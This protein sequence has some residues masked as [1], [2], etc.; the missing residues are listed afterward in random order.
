MTGKQ[1]G[2]VTSLT[3]DGKSILSLNFLK[4]AL[5]FWYWFAGSAAACIVAALLLLRY[6]TPRYDIEASLLVRDDA[7]GA[8]FEDA[9][10]FEN[11]GH[12]A[13]NS[14]VDNEVE[15][16][17]SRN[18]M[19][20]VVDTLQLQ[21]RCIAAGRV[22]TSELYE[23]SPF[24]INF[25]QPAYLRKKAIYGLRFIGNDKFQI[26]DVTKSITATFGDTLLIGEVPAIVSRTNHIYTSDDQYSIEIAEKDEVVARYGAALK[27]SV[28]NKLANVVDLSLKDILPQ[29]GEA[30]L[31]ELIRQY[32]RNSIDDKNRTA[33]STLSFIA[34]NLAQVSSELAS[35]ETGIAKFKQTNGLV[36]LN[37]DSQIVREKSS[38][39]SDELESYS[40]KLRVLEEL[41]KYISE[42]PDRAIPT[43][44]IQQESN[45]RT[46]VSQYNELV[47]SRERNA[48]TISASH[49]SMRAI[50]NQ[51]K[52]LKADMYAA[53]DVQKRELQ[54][55]LDAYNLNT[56]KL[57][58]QL[59]KIPSQERIYIDYS[60]QQQ[61]KQE[62]YLFLLKK[63]IETSISRSSTIANARILDAPKPNLQ[64][65][66]PN[67]QLVLLIAGCL[68]LFIPLLILHI[69]QVL[70][71]RITSR[72][73]IVDRCTAPILGEIG[74]EKYHQ[75][76]D[77]NVRNIVAE[78]FRTLRT[79]IL[80]GL[81][82]QRCQTILITSAVSGEGKSFVAA[83]LAESFATADKKVL[84]LELDLRRPSMAAYL[85]LN[86]HGFTDY[87]FKD[88]TPASLVQRCRTR[89]SFDILTSG[90]SPPNPAELFSTD[91]FRQLIELFKSRYD[92]II[93]DTPP[94]NLVTDARIIGSIADMSLYVVRH[95][96]TLLTNLSE[97]DELLSTGQLPGLKLIYNGARQ[98]PG[99]Q[100]YSH[101][102]QRRSF[103]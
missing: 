35:I 97:I 58:N 99:Y 63:R 91:R 68:S 86:Y 100:Y 28:T 74:F 8:S 38:R 53:L 102:K 84:L 31:N 4:E 62:L 37:A 13:V 51:L 59:A 50:E 3:R 15:I 5:R 90:P 93:V 29:K 61:I 44:L 98:R 36:D 23:K 82:T 72:K 87:M 17:R 79:N 7:R 88:L 85:R 32:L 92:H 56:R 69:R 96:F 14:S 22:K 71:V 20:H 26:S 78:Q 9:A 45:F 95:D 40:L 47:L 81:P 41:G 2:Q 11:F 6:S 42:H 49:P 76:F 25:L 21:V 80:F 89:N 60:R 1:L 27:V 83:H 12:T 94:V 70:T 24:K 54:I 66:T 18:L 65:V 30:I 55:A 52:M 16:L 64:P 19:E 39:T 75:F 57:E 10:L 48:V 77:P 67:Q 103:F 33:D 101:S 46:L 73:D 34:S 43:S